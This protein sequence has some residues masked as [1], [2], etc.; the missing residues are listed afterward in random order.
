MR[1]LCVQLQQ[2]NKSET[3]SVAKQLNNAISQVN[4]H[5]KDLVRKYRKEVALRKKYHNEL[6]EL[7]GWY[8]LLKD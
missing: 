2:L 7:K 1:E 8:Y 6:V 5:N 3:I 4:E